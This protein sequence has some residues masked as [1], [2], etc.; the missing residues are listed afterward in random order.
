MHAIIAEND[1]SQWNDETGVKYHF[2]NTYKRI[3]Q[4]GTKVI[5][6]KSGVKHY[7]GYAVIGDVYQDEENSKNYYAEIVDYIPFF[8]PI[9][10][11]TNEGE[12]FEDPK[13][14][15][16]WRNG[17]RKISEERFNKILESSG[18]NIEKN[19]LNEPIISE[20]TFPDVS[21]VKISFAKTSLIAVLKPQDQKQYTSNTSFRNS[22][23]STKI[24]N[25]G[26]KLIMTHLASILHEDEIKTL[27]HHAIKNEKFGYDISYTNLK[28]ETIY[29]E[30]KATTAALFNNFLITANELSA[31][32][33]FGNQYKIYLVNNVTTTDVKIEIIENISARLNE[34]SYRSTPMSF[35]IEKVK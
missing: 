24:G 21:E 9:K 20:S 26:E 14:S 18:L 29:I 1:V 12:Y 8:S 25:Y 3:L 22:K 35:K 31:A 7:F 23:N 28:K 2:P 32:K 16:H 11:K 13:K 33:E 17:V 4:P 34:Q 6:Y 19:I 27:S 10:F 30:V 15:N 5:Y